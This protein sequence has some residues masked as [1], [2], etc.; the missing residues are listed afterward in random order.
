MRDIPDEL[1]PEPPSEP[2]AEVRRKPWEVAAA[3]QQ[4]AGSVGLDGEERVAREKQERAEESS[5][6]V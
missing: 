2:Q 1:A 5:A 3:A 6:Q 4:T